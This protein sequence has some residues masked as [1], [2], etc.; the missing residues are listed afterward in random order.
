MAQFNAFFVALITMCRHDAPSSSVR[1]MGFTCTKFVATFPCG[2]GR[3]RHPRVSVVGSTDSWA[4]AEMRLSTSTDRRRAGLK[5]SA[6]A[7][8][9]F[10]RVAVLEPHTL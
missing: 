6:C 2:V 7:V 10:G 3:G 8:Q 1:W 9:L 4:S 5:R